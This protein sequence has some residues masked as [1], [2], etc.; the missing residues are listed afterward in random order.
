[1][2]APLPVDLSIV[3]VTWNSAPYLAACLESVRKSGG[4]G[5]INAP[6]IYMVD[7]A[8]A[9]NSVAL[10]RAE[11]PEV[12]LIANAQNRGFATAVNQG[13]A[14]C[15]GT[16]I[17]LLNPDTQVFSDTVATLIATLE[18]HPNAAVCAPLLQNLDG[19]PQF[20]WARFPN[21]RSEL[22]GR[23]DRS[24]SPYP[25]ENFSH[26]QQRTKMTPFAVDWVG[27]ACFLV[28]RSALF[29]ASGVGPMD[30]RF[31][32]YFEET[33]WCLRLRRAGWETLLVPAVTAV[34]AGGHSSSR[35]PRTAR[36]YLW[37]SGVQFFRK[38]YGAEGGL[39]MVL[40]TLRYLLSGF[41]YRETGTE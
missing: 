33:D 30:E 26:A 35:I 4:S 9:D 17:L 16:Y 24:Q 25:L 14:A 22:R 27:G 10:V 12:R 15:T 6:E 3:I 2:S 13:V 28:R 36:R 39:A 8:S 41:K 5:F 40:S 21:W 38:W 32:L 20:N 34:H 19:S 31:F 11:F 1:M 18:D 7:N 37:Q 23:L 29:G